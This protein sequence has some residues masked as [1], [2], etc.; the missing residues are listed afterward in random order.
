MIPARKHL[1]LEE[2]LQSAWLYET[3]SPHVDDAVVVDGQFQ[4]QVAVAGDVMLLQL[5]MQN[6]EGIVTD[7]GI[8]DLEQIAAYGLGVFAGAAHAPGRITAVSTM[9]P[10]SDTGAPFNF[11]SYHPGG[12]LFCILNP[13]C[14]SE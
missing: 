3:L 8:R 5:K 7:A 10:N 14:W 9:P 12:K 2:G 4:T 13:Y 6:A 1:V 11:S